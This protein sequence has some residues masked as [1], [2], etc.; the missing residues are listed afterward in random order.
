MRIG[1]IPEH[2]STPLLFAEQKGLFKQKG[3][4]IELLEYPSGSGHLI[5]SLKNGEIDVAIGLTELFVRGLCNGDEEY[6][7][8]GTYVESP[9][10]WAV[11]TGAGRNEI[12][13]LGQLDG[14][15][16]GISRIGSGSYVMSFVMALQEKFLS[17]SEFCVLDTFAN[18]RKSVNLSPEVAPSDAFMWELFTTK[19]YYDNGELKQIGHIYTPW[20]S[21]VIVSG[22]NVEKSELGLFSDALNEGIDHFNKN[23]QESVEYIASNLDYTKED[24][25]EW[26]KTVKFAENVKTIDFDKIAKNTSKILQTAGVVMQNGESFEL[27]EQRL[28][29][30]VVK[31]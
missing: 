29:S 2:F 6:Q 14:K 20:P 26:L 8:A 11:S 24:A 7:I 23:P 3:L 5:Q 13:N 17:E 4:Q 10:C 21:W 22:K 30:G 27:I 25:Q 28:D 15:R 19:K 31:W 18:L 12:E 1:F 9:L 16:I